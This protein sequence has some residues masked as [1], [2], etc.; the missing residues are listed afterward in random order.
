VAQQPFD[1]ARPELHASFLAQQ[2]EDWDLLQQ[3][4]EELVD[5]TTQPILLRRYA[6][7][8]GRLQQEELAVCTWFR[9]CWRFPE[10]ADAMAREAEPLWRECW[11]R[12]LELEPE[13]PNRDFPAW[14]LVENPALSERL[15][16][17]GCLPGLSIPEDYQ[18]IAELVQAG[19]AAVPASA[20]IA[21]RKRLKAMNPALFKHYLER[22]G[23]G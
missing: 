11:R 9:L 13:L 14:S 5:W 18:S 4:V 17:A 6:Q 12:F 19:V 20:L 21:Q 23:R 8:C 22:F 16:A 15:L 3:I 7:A 1:P 2:L 10:Q